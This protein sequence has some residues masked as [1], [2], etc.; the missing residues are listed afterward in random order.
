MRA[1]PRA[2]V[3]R[4]DGEGR[5]FLRRRAGELDVGG[6]GGAEL[7]SAAAAAEPGAEG[8]EGE[9]GEGDSD[10]EAGFGCGGEAGWW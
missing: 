6:G 10:G 9:G 8:E 1:V 3:V 7:A 2:C 4:V 5:L